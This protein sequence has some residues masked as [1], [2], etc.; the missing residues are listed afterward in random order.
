MAHESHAAADGAA[1]LKVQ[2]NDELVAFPDAEPFI[3]G[4]GSTL[5]PVRIVSEKL[6]FQVESA[7]E[8]GQVAVTIRNK[9][10]T[11]VL[12]ANRPGWQPPEQTAAVVAAG[13][14][15][16]TGS[17][18]TKAEV[19]PQEHAQNEPQQEQ[20]P[21]K[22]EE[23]KASAPA[24]AVAD[25]QAVFADGRV[26]VPLRFVSQTF[27]MNVQ[28]DSDNRIA[29]ID[30]DGKYHAPAWYA[31][32]KTA[33]LVTENAKNYMGV[34]Y[35]WGG[36]SPNGFDCSGF[37]NYILS[38]YGIYLPRTS[39]EMYAS[40]GSHVS[41]PQAGDLVFFA[42]GAVN[43]VGIYIGNNQFISATSSGG[44]RIDSLTSNYWGSRYVGAK[45]V[46]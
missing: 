6:G 3:D 39:G 12:R 43:H 30:A 29:I 26:Y 16:E 46:L 41:D 32:P 34:P 31:P 5:V 14:S 11:I 7:M 25:V 18:Q 44:V 10:K 42:K 17:T 37:V 1:N 33:S 23:A 9:D 22:P 15:Q 28:W 20:K 2:I 4:T 40:A 45:R 21:A 8:G 35:V 24:V 13:A 36:T 27:G 38:Q 19:T